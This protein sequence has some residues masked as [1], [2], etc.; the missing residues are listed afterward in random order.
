MM[1]VMAR[2]CARL[3][4][5]LPMLLLFVALHLPHT[6]GLSIAAHDTLPAAGISG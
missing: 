5:E 6:V 3:G 2:M 1:M 4:L